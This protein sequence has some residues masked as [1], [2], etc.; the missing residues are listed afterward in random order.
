[1]GYYNHGLYIFTLFFSAVYIVERLV[2]Q[3]IYVPNKEILQ[4][5]DLKSAVYNQEWF[6]IKSEL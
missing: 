1:M 6:Q 3:T 2:L 5:L 4:F